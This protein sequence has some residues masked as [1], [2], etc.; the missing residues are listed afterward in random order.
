MMVIRRDPSSSYQLSGDGIP[1]LNSSNG[2][3]NQ[4]QPEDQKKWILKDVID[5]GRVDK[6]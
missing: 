5:G 3:E 4:L 6:S 1:I 2:L